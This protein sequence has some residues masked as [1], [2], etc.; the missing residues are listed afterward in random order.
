MPATLLEELPFACLCDLQDT[1]L[2]LIHVPLDAATHKLTQLAG[3][4]SVGLD[5]GASKFLC[6]RVRH[7]GR[8]R[9]EIPLLDLFP[10]YRRPLEMNLGL[11][12][13]ATQL[14]FDVPSRINT[15]RIKI[16]EVIQKAGL[17]FAL[18]ALAALYTNVRDE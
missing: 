10:R 8:T 5:R 11:G 13:V 15:G 9:R 7:L 18:I 16:A 4:D 12:G 6:T 14:G 2:L 1:E 17:P 3:G